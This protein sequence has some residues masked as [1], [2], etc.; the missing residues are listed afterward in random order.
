MKPP[1]HTKRM[2]LGPL[3]VACVLFA[4]CGD[5]A[6]ELGP[7]LDTTGT[8]AGGGGGTY[9]GSGGSGGA[10][11]A[12]PPQTRATVVGDA[13]WTVTFDATA[14]AA[15]ATNCAYTRHYQGSQDESAPWLCPQCEITFRAAVELVA[16]AQDCYPQV[17][18]VPSPPEEW[19]GYGGGR[20][21]RGKGGPA[22]E[23]GT[24]TPDA[25]GVLWAN[26]ALDQAAPA[27]GTLSFDVA[28][29][30]VLGDEQG[31]PMN[32][33]V[34]APTYDCG[35]PKADPPAYQGD[36]LL[37]SGSMVPDGIFKDSCQ[38]VV[39]LHDFQGGYLLINMSAVNC[40]ACRSMA[41]TEEQFIADM[42]AQG[43]QVWVITLLAPS[44]EDPLGATT[45]TMIDAWIS[46][47]GLSAPVLGDRGWG[48]SMFIPALADTTAYPG[49]IIADPNLQVLDFGVGFTS[50]AEIE[51]TIVA[52]A[53]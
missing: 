51:A 8:G 2:C 26:S 21:W 50:Y 1:I 6:G 16:G 30:F 10:G 12:T 15:G 11:G 14:Q 5:D 44:L 35:W 41:D 43:I 27:G 23:Q 3:F 48:L 13:T 32:G 9:I 31:D 28:G 7:P 4:G 42:A 33:W 38:Q 52:D 17:S 53:G 36:Y 24:A 20:W 39:R 19:L 34:V 29:E 40:P 37:A 22:T 45:K 46:S 47:F 49:W 18:D 25:D